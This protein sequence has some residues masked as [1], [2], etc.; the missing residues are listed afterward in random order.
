MELPLLSQRLRFGIA[1]SCVLNVAF[2]GRKVLIGT[3]FV[4]MGV[5]YGPYTIVLSPTIV[6][7]RFGWAWSFSSILCSYDAV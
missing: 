3:Y 1:R 2:G 4:V 7:Q 6:L 5:L